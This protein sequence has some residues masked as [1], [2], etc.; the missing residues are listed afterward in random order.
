MV[1]FVR[2]VIMEETELITA[3]LQ[4]DLDS[5]N[6][7]VLTYQDM[8]Y[9]HAYYLLNDQAAAEDIGQEA[10]ILAFQKLSQFRGGSFRAWLIRIVTNACYDEIRRWK[11]KRQVPLVPLDEDG[12]ELE[13]PYWTADQG[14]SVEELVEREEFVDRL[15][16]LLE[17]L[18]LGLK[19]AVVMI[20]IQEMDYAEAAQSLGIPMGTLKSRLVRGRLKLRSLL[21]GSPLFERGDI[22]AGLLVKT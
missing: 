20:D 7:L 15:Q 11:R 6:Q 4:G 13:S 22:P 17:K 14:P 3:A 12:D 18:P 9:T 21:E 2:K 10:F 16:G 5:F 19:S 8:V 1:F